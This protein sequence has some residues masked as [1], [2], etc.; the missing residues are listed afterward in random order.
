MELFLIMTLRDVTTI[1]SMGL[2]FYPLENW[3]TLKIGAH[4]WQAVGTIGT[5]Y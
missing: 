3:V 5:P 4:D 1:S 2:H